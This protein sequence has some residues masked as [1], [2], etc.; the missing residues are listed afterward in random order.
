MILADYD[1]RQALKTGGLVIEP[2]LEPIQ[3]AS[4]DLRLGPDYIRPSGGL[5]DYREGRRPE[6]YL[7]AI[8]ATLILQPGHFVNVATLEY[9]EIPNG[10]VGI[11]VG[12]SS[13]ARD[14]LQVESAGY[15]D[16]GW[17]GNLTL[18]LKNLGPFIFA[19]HP[20]DKI[21]QIRFELTVSKSERIYGDPEL[22][23]H[24]NGATGPEMGN[25]ER[26]P[27]VTYITPDTWKSIPTRPY[28]FQC[29]L[30][31]CS[32]NYYGPH[33][34]VGGVVEYAPRE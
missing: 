8:G 12:K 1:I 30:A 32:Q 2:L 6:P 31:A 33:R 19:L 25:P 22:G 4:V 13:R 3:P 34:H 18:E 16:P 10:M 15:V 11:I 28:P 24:Y 20:G 27:T 21:A 7:Q 29:G 26:E 14:G 5:I 9:I 23:S 17:K